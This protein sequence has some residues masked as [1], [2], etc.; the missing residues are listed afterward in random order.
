MKLT[1]LEI[2][3]L[4]AICNSEYNDGTHP[5]GGLGVWFDNP[6]QNKTLCGGVCGSLTVKGAAWFTDVGTRDH[7]MGITEEGF[8]ALNEAE[9]EFTQ[10]FKGWGCDPFPVEFYKA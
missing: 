9:P 5:L 1:T 3:M 4:K 10:K 8:K 6:F 2:Q 7:A